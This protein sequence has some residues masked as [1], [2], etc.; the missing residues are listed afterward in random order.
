[1]IKLGDNQLPFGT[2][3]NISAGPFQKKH[4][5]QKRIPTCNRFAD[6]RE[7]SLTLSQSNG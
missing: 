4:T 6:S 5:V 2:F 7:T 3:L 1:M